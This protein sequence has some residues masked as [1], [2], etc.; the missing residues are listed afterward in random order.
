MDCLDSRSLIYRAAGVRRD[1]AEAGIC[2]GL[3]VGRLWAV[4]DPG[5]P[6]W[7]G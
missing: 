1:L 3:G 6:G 2:R 5:W 4:T 7:S